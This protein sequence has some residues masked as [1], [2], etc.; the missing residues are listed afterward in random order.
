MSTIPVQFTN[1]N[2]VGLFITANSDEER[3]NWTNRAAV[4]LSSLYGGCTITE[5]RGC[6]LDQSGQIVSEKSIYVWSYATEGQD[7]TDVLVS[8]AR[9]FITACNQEAALLVV[10]NQHAFISQ[11]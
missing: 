9:E 8:F 1:N 10:N 11:E 7:S 6:W 4:L 2:T 5:N 3:L